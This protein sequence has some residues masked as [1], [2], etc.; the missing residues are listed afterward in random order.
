M[1]VDYSQM[2][3]EEE[4]Y[5]LLQVLANEG[6]NIVTDCGECH[7]ILRE[8]FNNDVLSKFE[9][10]YPQKAFGESGEGEA[11][12]S[13]LNETLF[14]ELLNEVTDE[15]SNDQLLSIDNIY[16]ILRERFNNEILEIFEMGE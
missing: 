13:A 9:A 6:F 11:D 3:Q 14:S 2:T 1:T 16:S 10:K 8:H 12:Y 4:R 7:S 5:Y 15:Y